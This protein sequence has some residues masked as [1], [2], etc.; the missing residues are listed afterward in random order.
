MIMKRPTS[1]KRAL[2]T[3]PKKIRELLNKKGLMEAYNSRPPYQRND[4]IGWI[5]GAK[6]DATREKRL[7]QMLSELKKG[8]HYMN[9]AWT[10]RKLK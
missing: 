8:T 3:M 2:H 9:M 7:N 6:Q 1:L 5:L 4:Y 10:P